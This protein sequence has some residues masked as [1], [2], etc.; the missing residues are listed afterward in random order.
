[1]ERSSNTEA[2]DPYILSIENFK[3]EE[4]QRRIDFVKKRNLIFGGNIKF[5]I[6][7]FLALES[8]FSQKQKDLKESFERE[9]IADVLTTFIGSREVADII[10]NEASEAREI[11]INKLSNTEKKRFKDGLKEII[12]ETIPSFDEKIS[13]IDVQIFLENQESDIGRFYSSIAGDSFNLVKYHV[14]LFGIHEVLYFQGVYDAIRKNNIKIA[15]YLI[16]Q[17]QE[18]VHINH[19]NAA[20]QNNSIDILDHLVKKA[21][22]KEEGKRVIERVVFEYMRDPKNMEIVDY[23]RDYL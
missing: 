6:D 17:L 19:L 9:L 7:D 12:R 2:L 16:D 21:I 20:I 22:K 10:M 5:N 8:D 11:N 1:M 13:D 15:K 18:D 14:S 4:R 3:R 23:F